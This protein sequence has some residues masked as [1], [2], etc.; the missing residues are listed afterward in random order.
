MRLSSHMD[1]HPIPQDVTGFQFKLIGSMTIKQFGFIA[2]GVIPAVVIYYAPVFI[3]LKFIL[4]PLFG[5]TGVAMAFLPIEGRPL[6]VM[7]ANFIK[8]LITPNQYLFRKEGRKLAL[9]HAA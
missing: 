9:V 1:N 5:L 2:A 3:L 8:A 4:I 7:I 6:D